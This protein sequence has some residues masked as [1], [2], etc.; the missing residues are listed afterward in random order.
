[1]ISL[2]ARLLRCFELRHCCHMRYARRARDDA[3]GHYA[4][5]PYAYKISCQMLL[6]ITLALRATL[7]HRHAV[8]PLIR[9]QAAKTF[10]FFSCDATR[11]IL[12]HY[13]LTPPRAADGYLL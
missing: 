3:G 2:Q 11:E 1:M 10:F 7:I 9:R 8:L 5:T 13:L 12:R 4:D 6:L